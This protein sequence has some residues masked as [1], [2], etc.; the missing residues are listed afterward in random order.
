M[1]NHNGWTLNSTFLNAIIAMSFLNV[2][3]AEKK[4][5]DRLNQQGF[6]PSRLQNVVRSECFDFKIANWNQQKPK[7]FFSRIFFVLNECS[8][9]MKLVSR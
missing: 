2:L 9:Q 4:P 3:S 7:E 6:F 8:R 1:G 5:I